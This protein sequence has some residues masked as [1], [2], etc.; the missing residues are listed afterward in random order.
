MPFPR[1]RGARVFV[2]GP[3]P[4]R[5]AAVESGTTVP[6][7]LITNEPHGGLSRESRRFRMPG[8]AGRG[9]NV[10]MTIL[11]WPGREALPPVQEWSASAPTQLYRDQRISVE[12]VQIS[13]SGRPPFAHQVIRFA[14]E[15]VA[16]VVHIT[17]SAGLALPAG[18]IEPGE[19]PVDAA[20]REVFEETG[21]K[22]RDARLMGS[23]DVLPGL[24][25]KKFWFVFGTAEGDGVPE[26]A[27]AHESTAL[28]WVPVTELFSLMCDGLISAQPSMLALLY[29]ERAGMFKE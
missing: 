26:P 28:Y 21:C 20:S 24:A 22:L 16:A 13:I 1:F 11:N 18:G 15:S 27:D 2:T 23:A 4:H 6:A 5:P 8:E 19:H 25:D 17:S 3:L 12:Q 14:S 7:A 10:R 9:S 29:A